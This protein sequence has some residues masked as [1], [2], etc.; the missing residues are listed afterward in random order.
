VYPVIVAALR[1]SGNSYH[2]QPQTE[3]SFRIAPYS[4][5][6]FCF[7]VE[8][9]KVSLGVLAHFLTERNKTGLYKAPYQIIPVS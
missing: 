2:C 9:P 1:K 5:P 3:K 7:S 6:L 4:L 8:L